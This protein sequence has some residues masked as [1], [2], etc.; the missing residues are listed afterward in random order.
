MQR[1]KTRIFSG[2]VCEQIVFNVPD[3]VR[4]IK[5]AEPRP[6]FKTP[7]EREQHRIGISKRNHARLFNQNFGPSSLYSTLTFQEARRLR[8]NYTRRLM[9]HFPGARIL[10]YMGRGKGT[11]RIHLHMVSEGIP[12]DM[13][14]K[15]WG[16]G[17]IV[18]IEH[19]R[20]HNYYSGIDHGQDYTGLANYL[21]DHWRRPPRSSA[22]IQRTNRPAR[23]RATYW[24]RARP[25]NTAT[26]IISMYGSRSRP[27]RH[28]G[29]RRDR[30]ECKFSFL[31]PCK[32]VKFGDEPD[33]PGKQKGDRTMNKTKIDW[34][35]MSWNPLTGCRHGCPYC[36]ARRT[37]HR[38]DKGL[39][40]PAP[41]P[42][43]LHVLEKK[44]KAT[45]YPYGFEPTLHRYRLNQPERVE[46]PQTVFVC[47]MADL[48]GKWVPTSWIAQ[49]IDACLRAPQ[50]RYLFLTKNPARY[51]ELDH[52]A[53]LPHGENFWYGS[54]VANRDAAAMYP[55]PWAN[56]NTFWSMEPLLEPVAMGEAEGLPQWVILGAE[57]GSRRDKVIPRREWVDQI[58][59][60]C[61]ENEIPVFYKGNLREYFP[62]L[63]ASMF[64]WEV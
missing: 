23:Q 39:E 60:F 1:V 27:K 15:L 40:D 57:T 44:I 22:T 33:A 7:E 17:E 21:F 12:E 4:D 24:W 13:I 2:S 56:I 18:R 14:T 25:Q 49:V 36:Y 34:A 31:W 51:L 54:T 48:F 35:T 32:C 50:H 19:L 59:A 46:E 28:G 5:K 55:M 58:A 8:D 9:Y 42:G 3:R 64:P 63:P 47:S 41:L 53:L 20:E 52:L 26:Y 37:A 16:M 43:G 11:H 38:F 30:A 10:I 45:P 6:R 29:K 62:D 61:A